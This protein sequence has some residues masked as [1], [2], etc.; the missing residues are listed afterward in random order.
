M[1]K[2]TLLKSWL[3]LFAIIAGVGNLWAEDATIYSWNGNGSTSTAN[4]T[5]GTASAIG[6]NSNVVVG[7][8]QK[9][10]YCLKLGKGFS[11]GVYYIEIALDEALNGGETVTLGTFK[12]SES[13]AVFG[14][15][16]GTTDT[17]TLH[18]DNPVLTS[19]GTPSEWTVTVP[20]AA[21]NS[22]TIRVYRN[23]GG[24]TLFVSKLIVTSNSGSESGGEEP[25]EPT[26]SSEWEKTNLADLTAN[27][28]FVIVGDNGDTYAMSNN[29]GTGSAPT[30]VKV[31]IENDKITSEVAD[32]IK[33]N[34]SGDATNGYTFYPDG[35]TTTWLYCTNSNNGVRVGTNDNKSFTISDGGYLY[36]TATSRYVGIYNSQDWR[37]YT[38]INSNI[39]GQTFAFYKK[40]T[41]PNAPSIAAEN[42]SLAYD[43]TRGEIVYTVNNPAD[44][45]ELTANTEA[46]WLTVGTVG[47]TI[48]FT[49]TAN[50]MATERTATV[51]LTYIYNGNETVTKSVTVT[52]AGNPSLVMTIAEVR[53]QETGDVKTK[54]I[55]TSCVG[56]TGYIQDETAAICVYG[57]SLTVGN[58]ITVEGTLSTYNGLLEITSPDVE[59]LSSGN[60][61]NPEVMTIAEI[62]ASTKQG[63][64][65]K[66]ENATVTAISD[67]NTTIAQGEN[68]IVVRGI[69]GVEYEV[70]DVLTLTGNIGCYNVAQIANP[71]DVTVTVNEEASIE[72][73]ETAINVTAE[74][75]EGTITVTY[76][77]ITDVEAE[78]YFCD[79]DGN[80]ATYD[81]LT[82]SINTD[83]NIEYLVEANDG[84]A[85]TAYLKVY[86]LDDDANDVYSELITITQAAY[87]APPTPVAGYY[88]KVTSTADITDG[89][90]LIVYEGNDTHASVAFNGGLETLDHVGNTIDVEIE[91]DEIAATDETKAAEFTISV[92]NGT[93]MNAAG[94]YIG[95]TANS[96]GLDV[97][98]DV[99]TNTFEINNGE[100]VITAS[101]GC[102]LRYNYA[103]DQRRF[104]Y[105]K[106]GQQAIQLYKFVAIETETLAPAYEYT[107]YCS[108]DKA[109]DFSNVEG[110]EAYIVTKVNEASV[111]TKKVTKV[112]VGAGVILKKIGDANSFDIPV[113]ADAEELEDNLLIGTVEETEIGNVNGFTDYILYEG[114]FHASNAGTLAA[115]KAY[116]RVEDGG[117]APALGLDFN[118]EGTTGI[119]S[120]ERGALSVEG[121]YTLDGR[122][123]AQPT[124]GLYIVNGK[125]VMV[126]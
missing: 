43:A 107:T 105:Y 15:D 87:V 110:L 93:I 11:N 35:S 8:S 97:D 54:G 47:E 30:A 72:V 94:L 48:P 9:G 1:R 70:G 71:T 119:N 109:L 27:D 20:D 116:L 112:P 117:Q 32:K 83:N 24:T 111:S 25:T 73:K 52:Q 85:R 6:G 36:N 16:F 66:I 101:G 61:V 125:K 96:N 77:N 28:V 10:N 55:V 5:G 44:D 39:S 104:R 69:T 75:A 37:C 3:L 62:N 59:V 23:S 89:Q 91:D 50:E 124:K 17:Q 60:T 79:A 26:G 57:A 64:L 42:V 95:K 12:T 121:C 21:K 114:A 86:G 82:A 100:A 56:T 126:K 18:S 88:V 14:I 19:N 80:A 120:V 7:A 98:A 78:V 2:Q 103:S 22:K 33:W 65:V 67:Q 46:D 68:T 92:E 99:L 4:E 31:T 38:S 81:W 40:V 45:G 63:W 76:N 115:G 13:D 118:G 123:V 53:A 84:E 29:G 49:T 34:V 108:S 74:G 51:T 58:E 90:Y 122:R 41:D 113:I 106:S 102:T